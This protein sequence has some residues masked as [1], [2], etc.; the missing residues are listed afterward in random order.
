MCWVCEGGA[1]EQVGISPALAQRARKIEAVMAGEA[2][3]SEAWDILLGQCGGSVPWAQMQRMMACL[4]QATALRGAGLRCD[5][6]I[7]NAALG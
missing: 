6:A 7:T 3:P 4:D 2:V 5:V 1:G